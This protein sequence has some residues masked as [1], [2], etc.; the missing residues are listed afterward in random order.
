MQCKFNVPT[1]DNPEAARE[2]KE[3]ILTSEPDAKVEIDSQAHTV[4]IEA[5]A[6][7]ETFRELIVA[8]GHKIS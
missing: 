4:K 8:T 7:E 3:T 1:L 5:L 6:S 2:L